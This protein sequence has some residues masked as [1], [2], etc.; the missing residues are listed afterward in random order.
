M[1]LA[2]INEGSNE[3]S[4]LDAESG[5]SDRMDII[6]QNTTRINEGSNRLETVPREEVWDPCIMSHGFKVYSYKIYS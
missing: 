5:A 4:N 6:G 3:G 2:G 1:E